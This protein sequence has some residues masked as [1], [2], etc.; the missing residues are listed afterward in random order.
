MGTAN[1]ISMIAQPVHGSS[2]CFEIGGILNTLDVQLGDTVQAIP[3]AKLVD[4]VKT[5]GAAAGDPSRLVGDANGV[6][7]IVQPFSLASVRNEDRKASLDSAV[8]S[9]QNIYFSKYANAGFVISTIR[10]SY[11]KTSPASNPNLLDRL[12]DLA[13]RQM[14]ELDEAYTEDDRTGVVRS[15]SSSVETTNRSSGSS[16]RASK[17]Y[18]ESVGAQAGKGAKL[19]RVPPVPWE[20][21]PD[22]TWS[23]GYESHR[24]IAQ[25]TA[26]MAI[27]T[28]VNYEESN[29][30]GHAS[31][32]QS[33]THVDYEYRTPYIEAHAR[34]LRAQISLRNQ[35]FE[36]YM[37]SQNIPHLER[38]FANELSSV[39]N[40]VY[41]LQVALLRS[42]LIS[43]VEGRVTGVYK[44]PGDAVNAGEPVIRV[45]DNRLVHLLANLAHSGPIPIG[46]TATVTTSLAGPGNPPIT[47]SG[48]VASV[49]GHASGTRWEV[50]IRI[51]NTDGSGNDILPV[52]Y[53]F[54]PEYTDV[55]IA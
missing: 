28:G 49:R 13:Q 29:N 26:A 34:N 45:E 23:I 15:T 31:G 35:K 22:K 9:R 20:G 18:Q 24:K 3:Y 11:D 12:A 43:P 42:F 32:E 10:A 40:D 50:A 16:N 25:S 5:S 44:N 54:D 51:N 7:G 38:I 30:D 8:N 1:V 33:A 46:A 27:T 36:A 55:S 21:H 2:L 48:P 14:V 53:V 19:P 47:V 4:Y 17:F 37:F 6:F 41:Q 39:D 52:G